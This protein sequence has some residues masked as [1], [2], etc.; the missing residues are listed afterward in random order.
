MGILFSMGH[1]GRKAEV[2]GIL[3]QIS[4][5]I[6]ILK[7]LCRVSTP[8]NHRDDFGRRVNGV[9]M[10]LHQWDANLLF[11]QYM[12]RAYAIRPYGIVGKYSLGSHFHIMK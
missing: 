6:K 4:W 12:R 3:L 7:I 2:K 5:R 11:I 9:M 8:L 10:P 1:S